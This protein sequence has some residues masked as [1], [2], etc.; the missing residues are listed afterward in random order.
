MTSAIRKIDASSV[1]VTIELGSNDL[2]GYVGK[3]E[4]RIAQSLNLEGFRKGKV[5][6]EAI[7]Q[8]VGEAE[9]REEALQI[10]VQ[11]SLE[12]AIQKEGLDVLDQSNFS[13]K[14]NTPE[15]LRYVL[16][17]TLYPKVTLGNYRGIEIIKQS[18]EVSDAELQKVLDDLVASRRSGDI[19][20][21]LNDEFAKSL[22]HFASLEDLKSGVKTGLL[23]EKQL[24]ERDRVRGEVLKAIIAT[25]KLDV[26]KLMIERQL[27]GM[28]ANFDEELHAQG[29]ELGPYLARIKKTQDQ[30]RAEWYPKAEDQVKM[31][32]VL[33]AVGKAEKITITAAELQEALELRLQQYLA[34]RKEA[35]T[36]EALKDLDLERIKRGLFGSLLNEKIFVF[37]ES[38]AILTS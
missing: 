8:R 17:L 19:T 5:P 32:L 31:T 18:H 4:E 26:P 27:D 13:I 35:G 33:H 30:L 29:M 22:G 25:S 14:D 36:A 2:K 7:R 9:L 6:P 23:Q 12:E 11:E 28:I 20:P 21:E 1:E 10:A 34:G 15:K 37:L 3:A 16:T 24:R 38:S